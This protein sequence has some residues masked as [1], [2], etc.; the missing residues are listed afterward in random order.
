MIKPIPVRTIFPKTTVEEVPNQES[1]VPKF[2]NAP[3][4]IPEL[5]ME[6]FSNEL[7]EI[8][9]NIHLEQDELLIS[10]IRGE[11]VAGIFENKEPPLSTERIKSPSWY[12]T[13]IGRLTTWK[14]S[15]GC[16]K[17][18]YGQQTW[19]RAKIN[20]AMELARKQQA[21]EK[22]KTF[23][24]LVPEPYQ[25]FKDIFDKKAAE[26][27]PESRSFDH[28]IDLK[29]DFLPR[30]CKVYPLSPKEQTALDE[31]LEENLRKGYIQPS[32]SPMA[33]PFF[34][35]A[36][37]DGSLRPCQDYRYLNDGTVKNWQARIYNLARTA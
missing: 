3:W 11:P 18:S 2:D 5:A 29:L 20:P 32:N 26:R 35:V 13:G 16:Y 23:E 31:F 27:F 9:E 1:S 37:K 24:D 19:I 25:E 33:S 10:Y 8:P 14:R 22:K 21:T 15:K 28:A 7:P 6:E 4:L 12:S 30:N 17:W 36:K 34:F